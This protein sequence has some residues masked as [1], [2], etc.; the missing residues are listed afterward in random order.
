M[1]NDHRP[2]RRVSAV[3]PVYNSEGSIGEVVRRLELVLAPLTS[4]FEFVLVNDGS[5]DRSWATIQELARTNPRVRAFDLMRNFGQHNALL[6]GIRAARFEIIVTLDDDLQNP[7][8]EVPVLLE[9]LEEGF[10]V[11]YGKPEREQHGLWRDLASQITKMA[12]QRA[13]GIDI[14]RSVGPF[15]AIR[16]DVRRAFE[17]YS[18]PFVSVDVLLTWATTRFS[19]VPVRHEPRH[20]GASNYTMGRLITHALNMLTG[21]ST[22]PLQFASLVGFSFTLF[23]IGVLAFVL[24]R[25]L[26]QGSPVPGFPFLASLIA[27]FSGAQMFAIGVIGEYLARLHFRMMEKPLY[28]VR[29]SMDDADIQGSMRDGEILTRTDS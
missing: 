17:S 6:C 16:S 23:G 4:D 28:V 26:I 24:G 3:I 15:R 10:D 18:S 1:A 7:P 29:S 27:I 19:A 14:A 21:F 8:E 25:Y 20:V 13:M 22:W 2:A 9:R 11:V 12:L 5:R